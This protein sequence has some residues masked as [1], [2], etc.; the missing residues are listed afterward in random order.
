MWLALGINA[1]W[2]LLLEQRRGL[3]KPCS[4]TLTLDVPVYVVGFLTC[5]V[6]AEVAFSLHLST[7]LPASWFS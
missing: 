2:L 7:F 4:I 5:L 6:L 1:N 3:L